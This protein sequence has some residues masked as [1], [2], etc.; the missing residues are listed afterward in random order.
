MPNAVIDTS[1]AANTGTGD[2]PTSGWIQSLIS[3]AT[4]L[5]LTKSQLDTAKQVT[6]LQLDRAQKGLPPLNI[7]MTKLGVPTVSVGLTGSATNLLMYGGL[8]L[9]G[10]WVLT[11][12]IGRKRT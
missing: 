5:Y 7:D 6:Q 8:A 10:F 3:G 12:I 4:S 2:T 1:D 11:S 9:L